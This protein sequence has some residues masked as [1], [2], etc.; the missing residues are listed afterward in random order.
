MRTCT[1]CQS[2]SPDE[3]IT[4]PGCGADLA[5]Y[6]ASAVALARLRASPR[7]GRIRLIVAPDACPACAAA[8]GHYD[9][10]HAPEL[11]VRGCSTAYGCRCSY[12]PTLTEIYP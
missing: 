9:K 6:S 11:P 5:V 1:R 2:Q 10:D 3:T 7:V 12:E 4:C 8:E